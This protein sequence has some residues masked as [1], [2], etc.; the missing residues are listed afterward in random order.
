MNMYNSIGKLIIF[1]TFIA[2][3]ILPKEAV[4]ANSISGS[5]ASL[6]KV[7]MLAEVDDDVRVRKTEYLLRSFNSPLTA[8]SRLIVEVSDNYE[9]P[10]TLITAISGVE[11]GFCKTVRNFSFNCWGWHNGKYR[12]NSYEEAINILAK[13]LKNKYFMKGYDTPELMGPIYAPPSPSWSQKVLFFMNK[14]DNTSLVD[15]SLQITL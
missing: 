2:F 5:S 13:A 14:I 8:Y 10:W 7:D 3:F 11:T 1:L 9:L 6:I 15:Y 4:F 12:F